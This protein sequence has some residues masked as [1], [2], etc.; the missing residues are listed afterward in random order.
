MSGRER[1]R[2]FC[3]TKEKVYFS[4]LTLFLFFLVS[5]SCL[6]SYYFLSLIHSSG[7]SDILNFL[8]S[9]CFFEF[10]TN[11][12][13]RKWNCVFI[14]KWIHAVNSIWIRILYLRRGFSLSL[15]PSFSVIYNCSFSFLHTKITMGFFFRGWSFHEEWL[16]LHRSLRSIRSHRKCLN[17]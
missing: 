4:I 10:R 6:L 14:P 13:K 7:F 2:I 1:E 15:S 17:C 3:V 8:V 5:H 16:V 9:F 12:G 11:E